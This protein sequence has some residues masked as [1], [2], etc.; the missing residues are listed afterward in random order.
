MIPVLIVFGVA[1][2]ALS[3]RWAWRKLDDPRFGADPAY[4][5]WYREYRRSALASVDELLNSTDPEDQP[6]LQWIKEHSAEFDWGGG[7][8]CAL[9]CAPPDDHGDWDLEGWGDDARD[10]VDSAMRRKHDRELTLA[11]EQS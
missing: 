5:A 1:I 7:E 3:I 4:N 9:R 8:C 11:G 2:A 6:R 10:A